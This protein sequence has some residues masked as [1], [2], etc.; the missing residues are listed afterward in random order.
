MRET[1]LARSAEA[2]RKSSNEAGLFVRVDQ[3]MGQAH[4]PRCRR[5][6]QAPTQMVQEGKSRS[7]Q[8]KRLAKL[9]NKSLLYQN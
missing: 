5:K 9:P 6:V 4:E 1:D 7:D 3:P 8:E 2:L